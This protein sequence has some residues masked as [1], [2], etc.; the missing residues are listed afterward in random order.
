MT[1]HFHCGFGLSQQNVQPVSIFFSVAR[2]RMEGALES[3][4]FCGFFLPYILYYIMLYST[5]QLPVF[6]YINMILFS[7]R[8]IERQEDFYVL[9]GVWIHWRN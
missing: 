9:F 8:D 3:K 6:E 1:Q 2:L 5:I 4:L 7:W